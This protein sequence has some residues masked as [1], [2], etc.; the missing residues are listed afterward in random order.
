MLECMV[1]HDEIEL[2]IE[3]IDSC[4]SKRRA[5]VEGS[6]GPERVDARHGKTSEAQRIDEVSGARPHVQQCAATPLTE[7][8]QSNCLEKRDHGLCLSHGQRS[9]NTGT[10]EPSS[11]QHGS[12]NH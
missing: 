6:V 5:G 11:E 9:L 8:S 3:V 1:Q 10:H 12:T 4:A 2:V 7:P